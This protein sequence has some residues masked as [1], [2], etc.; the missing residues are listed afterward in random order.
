MPVSHGADRLKLL[1][2]SQKFL[3]FPAFG[4]YANN[5]LLAKQV[6]RYFGYLALPTFRLLSLSGSSASPAD[7]ASSSSTVTSAPVTGAPA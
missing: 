7:P 4:C 3:A 5:V 6:S 1:K 2:Q